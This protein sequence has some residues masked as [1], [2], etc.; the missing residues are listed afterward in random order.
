MKTIRRVAAA[1]LLSLALPAKSTDLSDLW[2]NSPASSESGWGVNV[3]HQ[4]SILFLTFFIYSTTG[5]PYWVVAPATQFQGTDSSGGLIYSG[6]LYQTSGPWF[7]GPFNPS[8]VVPSQVGTA[9]FT[10]TG[11]TTATLVYSV[12][13]TTVAKSVERQTFKNNPYINGNYFGGLI[14]D[15]SGCLLASNNGHF[16][17]QA[18]VAISGDTSNSQIVFQGSGGSCTMAGPYT[19]NGRMG[20]IQGTISCSNGD[21]GTV[22]IV[23][24]EANSSGVSARYQASYPNGCL[25]NGHFGGVSR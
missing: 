2:W 5:Q 3:A 20:Q 19:Q 13:G 18:L 21:S 6:P 24:I 11:V 15:A 25:E 9:T 4:E 17:N 16:E 1:L 10:A 7:G 12:S 23:E 22:S 8:S 14:G